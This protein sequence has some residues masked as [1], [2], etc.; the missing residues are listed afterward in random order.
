MKSSAR[1]RARYLSEH[2]IGETLA[3]SVLLQTHPWLENVRQ[4]FFLVYVCSFNE[5]HEGHQFEP[6]KDWEALTPKE[7]VHGY[8]NPVNGAYRLQC[9]QRWLKRLL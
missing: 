6:M 1:E 9:L 5:W 8:H 2:Q 3:T 4:G 7:R